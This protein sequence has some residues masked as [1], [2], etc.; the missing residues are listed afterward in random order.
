MSED[1]RLVKLA[2]EPSSNCAR[3]VDAGIKRPQFRRFC[4]PKKTSIGQTQYA[5]YTR[6]LISPSSKVTGSATI[7]L[8]PK[9]ERLPEGATV[10]R[11]APH[12]DDAKQRPGQL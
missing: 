12:A 3:F 2:R 6:F 5:L 1:V 8:A 4:S 10:A 9:L 11:H 7:R